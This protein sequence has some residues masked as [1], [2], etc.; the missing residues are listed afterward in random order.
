MIALTE[1]GLI[2]IKKPKIKIF[3]IPEPIRLLKDK[4]FTLLRHDLI[5][6]I[7]SGRFVPS[8]NKIKPIIKGDIDHWPKR[9][10]V[11]RTIMLEMITTR[12][13]PKITRKIFFMILF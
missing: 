10:L 13:K 12:I 4:S 6:T 2:K 9:K 8:E 5:V 3:A 11:K 7:I 1:I